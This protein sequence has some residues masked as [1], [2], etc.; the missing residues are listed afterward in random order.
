MPTREFYAC[1]DEEGDNTVEV[2]KI[3][4]PK[5]K[6]LRQFFLNRWMD[7]LQLYVLFDSISVRLGRREGNTC[8]E[9]LC[10][11][12]PFAFEISAS[13]GNRTQDR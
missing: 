6:F 8:N 10:V 12:I 11:N 3:F 7:D 1:Y 2:E 9:K 13:I 5:L 4:R